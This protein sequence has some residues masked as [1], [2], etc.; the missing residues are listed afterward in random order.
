MQQMFPCHRC[1]A[2]NLIGQRFCGACGQTFQYNCP[3][4]G[5]FVDNRYTACPN[6]NAALYWPTQQPGP[7]PEQ[8]GDTY[9]GQQS[10]YEYVEQKPEQK[11][12]PVFIA[13]IGA[14]ALAILIGGTIFAINSSSSK[15]T[16]P[17]PAPIPADTTPAPKSKTAVD[18]APPVIS[19][20]SDNV[21]ASTAIIRWTTDE[22]STSQV[23]YGTT[24]S[25]DQTSTP[26]NNLVTSHT[27]TLTGLESGTTYHY[28]VK[29]KDA[30]GNEATSSIDK[31]VTTL[32]PPDTTPPV[33]SQEILASVSTDDSTHEITA[34]ITWT[35]DEPA[36]SQ[37]EYGMNTM[38]GSTTTLDTSLVT[39]HSVSLPQL[40]VNKPYHFRVK[41]KDKDENEAV[42]G[43][44]MFY[45]SQT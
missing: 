4:C 33:I 2:Q 44:E 25:Y 26:D 17:T 8:M 42:S 24:T 28:R 37:V 10:V 23:E 15:E 21:T 39:S 43:D 35:T 9:Q 18:T 13:S 19:G 41:S 34:T 7:L 5:A 1:G 32:P 38:Y 45:T 6:C 16:S 22:P 29:S 40:T 3:S 31:R 14:L 11:K 12:S 20:F 36:T 30:R 27:V